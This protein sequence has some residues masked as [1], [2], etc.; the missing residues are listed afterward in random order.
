MASYR[1]HVQTKKSAD[2]ILSAL[3]DMGYWAEIHTHDKGFTVR[4]V[5]MY[6]IL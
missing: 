5:D 3:I 6:G 4:T 1:V 2:I